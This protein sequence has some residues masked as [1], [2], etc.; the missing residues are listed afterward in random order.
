MLFPNEI[1]YLYFLDSNIFNSWFKFFKT[2][3]FQKRFYNREAIPFLRISLLDECPWCPTNHWLI[4]L[5]RRIKKGVDYL[6]CIVIWN[7][8]WIE[9][10]TFT[11][12]HISTRQLIFYHDK[13]IKYFIVNLYFLD[14]YKFLHNSCIKSLLAFCIFLNIGSL[15]W[16]LCILKKF[17]RQNTIFS[18][19][20]STS[21]Y[22]FVLEE[23]F[24]V[25]LF[26]EK[27][28]TTLR[29]Y[30]YRIFQHTM[31]ET[32]FEMLRTQEIITSFKL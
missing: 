1:A 17:Q 25:L 19:I 29:I 12:F 7:I 16:F 15:S 26:R 2:K 28:I 20:Q 24:I 21:T 4:S 5:R 9:W 18:E 22:W 10:K 13:S 6:R 27:G 23:L 30:Q 31:I 14:D 11:V 3:L 8:N 32:C